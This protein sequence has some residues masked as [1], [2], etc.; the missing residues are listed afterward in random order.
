M[1]II[2]PILCW[3]AKGFS[4]SCSKPATSFVGLC[5]EHLEE[6]RSEEDMKETPC[7][8]SNSESWMPFAHMG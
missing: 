4:G 6:L 1:T 8:D 5:D 3:R 7:P 2:S